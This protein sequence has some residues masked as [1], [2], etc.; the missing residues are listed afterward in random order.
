MTNASILYEKSVKQYRNLYDYF[1]KICD[2]HPD[3]LFSQDITY[4]QLKE[5]VIQKATYLQSINIKNNSIVA[6]L[7]KNSVD[8]IISYLAAIAAGA[9]TLPLDY[10]LEP[11]A[12]IDMVTHVN[13]AAVLAD[14]EYLKYDFPKEI[15][16]LRMDQILETNDFSFR[17]PSLTSEDISTYLY[18]SGTTG[19]PKI[20]QLTHGNIYKTAI[21]GS[22]YL[23]FH[24]KRNQTV[25]Q[26]LPLYHVYGLVASFFA[27][28]DQGYK[29]V[30]LASLKGPDIMQ[31]LKENDINIFPAVP[32]LWE[33][34]CDGVLKKAKASSII[35]Y[36]ILQFFLAHGYQMRTI[37]MDSIVDKIFKPVHE[38]LGE[39][40]DLLV[41]G[42]AHF[43][44]KYFRYYQSMGYSMVEGYGLTE[45]SAPVI[46]SKREKKPYPGHVGKCL[47]GNISE[48]R[49][50]NSQGIG[51][52][53]V[54]GVSVMPGYL[55]NQEA[56]DEVFD[57][58]GWFNTGDLGFTDKKGNLH[59]AG[60]S[61]N[62]IVLDSGKNVYPEEIEAFYRNSEEIAEIAVF[63]RTIKD[64]EIVYA[65]IYPDNIS[66]SYDELKTE[67]E[68][69]SRALPSYK[70]IAK[71]AISREALPKTSKRTIINNKVINKLNNKEYEENTK[72]KPIRIELKA[73]DAKEIEIIN[74]LK[75]NMD[76]TILYLNENL[77]DLGY[78]SLKT[79]D[80]IA[81]TEK[82]LGIAI[83]DDEFINCKNIKELVQ[84][85]SSCPTASS[86]RREQEIF[87]GTIT[88]KPKSFINPMVEL[89]LFTFNLICI[90]FWR[91]KTIKKN[92]LT[93]DNDIIVS[94]HTSYLDI[95]VILSSFT[96]KQRKN[97]YMIGKKE[98]RYLRFI[99][100]GLHVVYVDRQSNTF[101]ALKAGA[102]ILRQG[103]SLLIF[104]EGTRTRT[105]TLNNFKTGAAFLAKGLNKNILPMTVI[106]AYDIFP[107]GKTIPRFFTRTKLKL[108]VSDIILSDNYANQDQ[109]NQQIEKVII[110]NLEHY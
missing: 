7:G 73:E 13:S 92:K 63:G 91:S 80:L 12:I 94:N 46:A 58:N 64:T 104:P 76:K 35:K 106:G 95:I 16:L 97:I 108:V 101:P 4:S 77:A 62:L 82:Q 71:F 53:W 56:N 44:D 54:K 11:K 89:I 48:I 51:E 36:K 74:F 81:N 110:D 69:M 68:N 34:I 75:E 52:I 87:E 72:A 90:L 39:N 2:Q 45:T 59:I 99:F 9:V 6:I 23:E 86:S 14:E 17:N 105:G 47:P 61:K 28:M 1:S 3:N 37:G 67:I 20:V 38:A 33:L 29:Y 79:M 83:N 26:L 70:I 43:K 60:R 78:D 42:G 50:K 15:T 65:V 19:N 103:K 10:N 24:K 107:P 66:I 32:Q 8:W 18:T 27:T 49:N 22:C 88:Y 96:I 40:M 31:S 109:L 25:L 100:P 57:E 5:K 93:I 98:L 21:S 30:F 41:T 85:L 55:N 102:D 84:Y